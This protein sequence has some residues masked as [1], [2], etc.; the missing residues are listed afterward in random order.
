MVVREVDER[1]GEEV[2]AKEKEEAARGRRT[3]IFLFHFFPLALF[4]LR[5]HRRHL[6]RPRHS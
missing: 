1:E 2:K 4:Y 6:Y 3:P 5:W